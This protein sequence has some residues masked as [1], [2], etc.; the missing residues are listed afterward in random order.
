MDLNTCSTCG[1]NTRQYSCCRTLSVLPSDVAILTPAVYENLEDLLTC[2]TT[3]SI[4]R[5]QCDR[6]LQVS[7]G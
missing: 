5:M 2:P 3:I 6:C 4:N 1:L 7:R